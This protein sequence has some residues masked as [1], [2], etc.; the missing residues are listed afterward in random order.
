MV[1][2]MQRSPLTW[3]ASEGGVQRVRPVQAICRDESRDAL[4]AELAT[5]ATDEL[6]PLVAEGRE[7]AGSTCENGLMT[8]DARPQARIDD[9]AVDDARLAEICSR[10][11][12]AELALFGSATRGDLQP[13]SDIDL[14]YVPAPDAHLGWK[15]EQLADELAALFGRPVDLVSKRYL[16]ELLREQ[17]LQDARNVYAA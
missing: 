8:S 14:L 1:H 16:H 9:P 7:L 10:Y 3:A 15:I 11:G 17:I 6:T 2:G 5:R 13:G 12:I 4:V